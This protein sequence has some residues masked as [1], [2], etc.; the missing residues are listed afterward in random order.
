VQF[1]AELVYEAFH[2][3]P[4]PAKHEITSHRCGECDRIRDD[5]SL[6]NARD[7]P[8]DMML[9]HSDSMPLLTPKAFRYY[10]WKD[11]GRK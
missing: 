8:D 6:H 10:L 11:T 3:A 9:Y 4:R 2:A 5:F 7:V 1:Q